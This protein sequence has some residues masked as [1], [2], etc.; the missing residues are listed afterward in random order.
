MAVDRTSGRT[1]A[2]EKY[3]VHLL[4]SKLQRT[5]TKLRRYRTNSLSVK[6]TK[7]NRWRKF[8]LQKWPNTNKCYPLSPTQLGGCLESVC[9]LLSLSLS[10]S[11]SPP[12][13]PPP[14][15]LS[16]SLSF[17]PLSSHSIIPLCFAGSTLVVRSP[18]RVLKGELYL[19]PPSPPV[20]AHA[21][22]DHERSSGALHNK[23]LLP[24]YYHDN[25][26]SHDTSVEEPA[27]LYVLGI[28]LHKLSK[29]SQLLVC[30]V[31]I[32]FFYLLY[33]YTQVSNCV[34]V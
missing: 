3:E 27:S 2:R 6:H 1:V 16:L 26:K 31:G 11:L 9:N 20:M 30:V 19:S 18:L 22:P 28:P 25:K 29:A 21:S 12:L 7:S 17:S 10:L 5:P 4:K 13:S 24:L 23:P 32:M 14:P 8:L 15:P 34:C 33:G